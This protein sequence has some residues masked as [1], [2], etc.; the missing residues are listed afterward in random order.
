MGYCQVHG[1]K[2]FYIESSLP[3]SNDNVVLFIH[4]AGGSSE[5]WSNQLSPIEG[6]RLFAL[7]LPGHGHS[8]GKAA[9]DI[10]EYSRFIADFIETLDLHF[11]I[12]VGH[13]MGGGIVL[14]SALAQP[15]LSWLKGIVLVDTGSRLRV[16]K[17][18]LE[19]L[20]Q[21]KLPFDI[22]PYLYSQNSTP[23]IL[24]QALEDM[25]KVQAEVYLADFQACDA[26][27]RSNEIQT[28][29]LPTCIICGENDRMTP[30]KY[31]NGLHEALPQSKLEIISS[32]GHM[33]MQESP[34]EVN[35]ALRQ[36]LK[37]LA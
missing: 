14:E 34:E 5:V 2:I 20:A 11:V 10:Q 1:E 3:N 35:R 4:G 36:F 16:N 9:S 8:E 18:T 17:K 37:G 30:L 24:T 28:L 22:I 6:Y 25:K 32:A 29:K 12:L 26:F 27:D 31:S 21:G 15:Q 19:Q 7:D 23:E 13:S 33:S